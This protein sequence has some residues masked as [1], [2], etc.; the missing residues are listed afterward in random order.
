MRTCTHLHVCTYVYPRVSLLW[1]E[2]A[3]LHLLMM[4]GSTTQNFKVLAVCSQVSNHS[5]LHANSSV[6]S[7]HSLTPGQCILV[8]SYPP[9]RVAQISYHHISPYH[10]LSPSRCFAQER[11][12][13]RCRWM[14]FPSTAVLTNLEL[15][16]RLKSS[17]DARMEVATVK[18]RLGR[19][20]RLPRGKKREYQILEI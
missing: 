18:G 20:P 13:I 17:I 14:P 9:L 5:Q 8:S 6:H 19:L 7:C 4:A 2:V 11:A 16:Q 15:G 3:G 1:D 12:E 10:H